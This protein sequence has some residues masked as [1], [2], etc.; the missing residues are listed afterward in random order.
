MSLP[1]LV[2]L[3]RS[4]QPLIQHLEQ[5]RECVQ[6]GNETS[7]RDYL[8]G[9]RTLICLERALAP[10]NRGVMLTTQE[11]TARFGLTPKSLLRR[12]ASG[13][14]QPALQ[15]GKL[16]RWSGSERFR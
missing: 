7:W 5:L 10:E 14:I 11:M 2:A 8:D 16:V 13:D 4:E 9:I 12:K 3:Q 1:G 6:S 15:R